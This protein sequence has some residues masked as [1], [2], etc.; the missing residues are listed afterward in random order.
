MHLLADLAGHP[1]DKSLSWVFLVWL[2]SH[3]P[4]SDVDGALNVAHGAL[5][6]ADWWAL[7]VVDDNG[8]DSDMGVVV[9]DAVV[10]VAACFLTVGLT[11]YTSLYPL[12][13]PS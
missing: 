9:A 10:G 11:L 1:L 4:E 6:S 7:M 8:G 5:L 13:N 12:R 2:E 3:S